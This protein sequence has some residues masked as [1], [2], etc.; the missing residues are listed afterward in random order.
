MCHD[1]REEYTECCHV[2]RRL[3]NCPKYYKQQSLAKTF[4]GRLFY[5]NVKNK[6]HCGRL[7]PHH[8]EKSFCSK[9]TVM[10]EELRAQH[11]GD[12]ALMA[13]RMGLVTLEDD[14]RRPFKEYRERRREAARRSLERSE[15]HIQYGAVNHNH[16][17]WIPELY[18]NPQMLARKE[19]YGRVAEAAPP[20]SSSRWKK[21]SA[22]KHL[23]R[24]GEREKQ[25]RERERSSNRS[26][27]HDRRVPAD[28]VP[29]YNHS[30][31]P[32]RP[33]EPAPTHHCQRRRDVLGNGA[34]VAP[35]SE[36]HP[37]PRPPRGISNW[38]QER[39]YVPH[40]HPYSTLKP[41]PSKYPALRRK[42]GTV[43]N[44]CPPQ[45]APAPIAVP[46]PE[47]QVYLN[48]LRSAPSPSTLSTGSIAQFPAPRPPP[49]RKKG[50]DA[51]TESH[52]AFLRRMM[53][54]G[55]AT[56][57]SGISD[58]SFACQDSVRL[59]NEI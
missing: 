45:P 50:S 12:G 37:P 3:V 40:E 53:G 46:L 26:H 44:I 33:T 41:V 51:T 30:Q 19:A 59:T 28:R 22:V 31:P 13:Y 2:S 43:F 56:P 25:S 32:K 18:Y 38:P 23:P 11:V 20:V 35:A 36:P 9:C 1:W 24:V 34:P 5:R 8:A 15:G 52:G 6:Q 29:A 16:R 57:D 54:I 21:P 39:Q 49:K 48:A 47:Y 14:F 58:I 17:V 4:W 42:P 27:K 10:V 55:P 7:I